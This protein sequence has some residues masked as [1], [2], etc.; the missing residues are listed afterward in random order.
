[1]YC[2]TP[3][4]SKKRGRNDDDNAKAAAAAPN[5]ATTNQWNFVASASSPPP[6]ALPVTTT[7]STTTTGDGNNKNSGTA[8]SDKSKED[9]LSSLGLLPS[10]PKIRAKLV[11]P[12]AGL[13]LGGV[14]ISKER[15]ESLTPFDLEEHILMRNGEPLPISELAELLGMDDVVDDDDYLMDNEMMM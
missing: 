5:G 12:T 14:P 3:P 15:L 1:M 2:P 11:D 7:S 8:K 4:S 6:S 10:V 13:T 9:L